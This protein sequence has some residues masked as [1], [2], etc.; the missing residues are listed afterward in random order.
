[1][2]FCTARVLVR[3]S[4]RSVF[5]GGNRQHIPKSAAAAYTFSLGCKLWLHV[6]HQ[7]P[8]AGH[9]VNACSCADPIGRST[10]LIICALLC[11]LPPTH[12]DDPVVRPQAPER[13]GRSH[14][15]HHVIF[16]QSGWGGCHRRRLVRTT[17]ARARSKI[18]L[19]EAQSK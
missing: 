12:S 3:A 11:W 14:C 9:D 10:T 2:A 15:C 6:C 19:S 17:G 16:V 1:M 13:L 18:W 4:T 7:P 5:F 8:A